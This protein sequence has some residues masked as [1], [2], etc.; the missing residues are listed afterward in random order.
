MGLPQLITTT[1]LC[2][3]GKNQQAVKINEDKILIAHHFAKQD[4]LG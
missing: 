4:Y 2:G 1:S 3:Y